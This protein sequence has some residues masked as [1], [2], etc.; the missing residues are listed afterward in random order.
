MTVS[1]IQSS[2]PAEFACRAHVH[3]RAAGR[4]AARSA[5]TFTPAA[6]GARTATITVTSNGAGSPQVIS[7]TG[8]GSQRRAARTAVGAS[9]VAF[10]AM[11]V[12]TTSA[13]NIVNI[14]N[15]GGTP[16]T[17]ASIA[18]S[19]PAEFAVAS[20]GLHDGRPGRRVRDLRVTFTPAA[21]GARSGDH[22][23]DEQRRRKP[24]DDQR[25]RHRHVRD[26]APG[27][28]SVDT[29]VDV[30]SVMVGPRSRRSS[31]PSPTSA[32]P[33]V[34]WRASAAATRGIRDR[35]VELRTRS[36]P[37]RAA[38]SRFTFTPSARRRAQRARSPS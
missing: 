16:V 11:T 38:R 25:Q 14:A 24:A 34:R 4:P 23:G 9:D 13:P 33:A 27:Q 36:P 2:A 29:A 26:R 5:L 30:G 31:S 20:S 6:A 8:T 15:T 32:A 22:H 12:G 37:A 21:A 10:G 18:S 28:L 1:G 3:D 35:A 19:A 17:V 7:A